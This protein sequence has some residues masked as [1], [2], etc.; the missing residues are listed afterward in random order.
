M[1]YNEIFQI[2]D[3]FNVPKDWIP[4]VR[5]MATWGLINQELLVYSDIVKVEFDMKGVS[6]MGRAIVFPDAKI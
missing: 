5:L 6:L 2:I 4:R 1:N 3:S